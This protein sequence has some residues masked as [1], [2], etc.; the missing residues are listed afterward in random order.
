M[1]WL[2]LARAGENCPQATERSFSARERAK[3]ERAAE[4]TNRSGGTAPGCE[5][6]DLPD[7]PG[8]T[9]GKDEHD[10]AR[11]REAKEMPPWPAPIVTSDDYYYAKEVEAWRDAACLEI[12]RLQAIIDAAKEALC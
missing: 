3:W 12:K 5:P 2:D 8:V 10:R 6:G 7:Y 4:Y 9:A 1:N 11:E